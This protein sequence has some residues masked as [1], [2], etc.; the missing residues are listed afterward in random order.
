MQEVLSE[1]HGI[2]VYQEQVMRILNRLGGIELSQAYSCIKAISK[3]KKDV[4]DQN[5]E[6]FI[7]GAKSR[8]L[9]NERAVEIFDLIVAF[10][11][12][13]FNKSHSTAYALIAYQTAYLKA[14]Y[15]TEFMAALMSSEM[16]DTD[17]L[18]EH[19]EDC[20]RIGLEV[21]APDVNRSNVEFAVEGNGLRYA[22]A[23]IK[24]IGPRAVETI[25][26][27]RLAGGPFRSIFDFCERVDPA[28]VNKGCLE[29][30]I[31][32]GAFDSVSARRA[33][34]AAVL[35][36]AMQGGSLRHEDRRRG[37]M[38]MFGTAESEAESATATEALP[39][40]PEWPDAEKLAY[41]KDVL[42]F[43]ISGHP[44]SRHERELKTF[45]SHSTADLKALKDE[46]EVVVGGMITG[47]KWGA[48]K[49]PSRKGNS[50]MARFVLEDFSGNVPC[51]MFPDDV[52][53]QSEMIADDH[54][55]L[56]QAKVDHSREQVGLII[57][58]IVPVE[59][60]AEHFSRTMIVRLDATTHDRQHLERLHAALSKSAGTGPTAVQ[61][62]VRTASGYRVLLKT[63][64]KL[65]VRP[66][67]ELAEA[68]EA[69]VGANAIRLAASNGN[70]E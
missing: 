37:Q 15:P 47:V 70:G 17:S 1:T 21:G 36:K 60:A 50:R 55:C 45:S 39:D 51:V 22:L 13:G 54:I 41:E 28:R 48:T 52:A 12:Y 61:L 23:A 58:K 62:E 65:R 2:M 29:S 20:R 7:D 32:A 34:L 35:P 40:L 31:K 10:G 42:G 24:G 69:A 9:S 38:N 3:K 25:V 63:D 53:V 19:I 30:L 27:A 26:E 4:I 11:G 33:Q 16:D 67:R 18:V 8:G 66:T 44:L 5:R 6:Q 46:Q 57:Q 56:V 49:K 68:V 14:H 59:R 43:Y 64:A